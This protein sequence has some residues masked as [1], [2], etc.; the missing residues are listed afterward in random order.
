VKRFFNNLKNLPVSTKRLLGLGLVVGFAVAL[1]LFIWAVVT[2][3]FNPL[4]KAQQIPG[5]GQK[6]IKVMI[7]DFDPI[8]VNHGNQK[9]SEY[10]NWNDPQALEAS[11]SSTL[12]QLSNG[13]ANF[14][15][16]DRVDANS[17]PDLN[18]GFIYTE[19]SYLSCLANSQNCHDPWLVN[20]L[21]IL[22][23]N[24]VCEKVNSG[25]IDELW[26]WGGPWFGYYEAEMTG[27]DAF[28][29]NSPPLLGSSCTKNLH[30]MGFSYERGLSEMLEDFGHRFE[31]T[32]T[33][34]FTNNTIDFWTNFTSHSACGTVHIPPNGTTDYDW[35][36][37]NQTESS[38]E[39]YANYPTLTT[40][41]QTFG[42]ERWGCTG[43]G[44]KEF[45]LNHIPKV[46]STT[47][48][49]W[50][51]WWKY[52]FD[53]DNA[54]AG[55]PTNTPSATPTDTPIPTATDTPLPTNT[56]TVTPTPTNLSNTYD[57]PN[58]CNGT[59]GSNSNCQANYFCYNG[60]CRNPL[61]PNDASCGQTTPTPTAK[62]ATPK[63]SQ[64]PEV[65]YYKGEVTT[66]PA[67]QS[68]VN[69]SFVNTPTPAPT[70]TSKPSNGLD[71]K[72]IAI[73]TFSIIALGFGISV[74]VSSFKTPPP[75]TYP[76]N[77]I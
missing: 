41:T 40:Q 32:M 25:E 57:N 23:D 75:P 60:Y 17:F 61:Y 15:I 11:Y 73:I 31:G 4:N 33:H 8:L 76:Q 65:V 45:W 69:E 48:G 3:N 28:N 56:P 37:T 22:S 67:S 12:N 39:D 68:A 16:V 42:C 44:W 21:K 47:S 9:L 52:V 5:I 50:D 70:L 6:N 26:L 29:T 66:K 49:T 1:P 63:A 13:Y 34:V 27:P 35:S 19:S 38:C 43:L 10:E 18:D 2:Q 24:Q 51:N 58:S 46:A 62:P 74:L 30:I 55:V 53:Y 14:Q 64:T 54:I 72:Y 77:P 36:N 71:L 59:C 20:Y 7:I